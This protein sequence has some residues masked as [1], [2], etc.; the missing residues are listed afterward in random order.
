MG[1]PF[2]GRNSLPRPGREVIK[3]LVEDAW[4]GDEKGGPHRLASPAQQGID[5]VDGDH[6]RPTPQQ[7]FP[8]C[9]DVLK[10]PGQEVVVAGANV[11]RL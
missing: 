11:P 4:L 7:A 9:R 8:Q 1:G 2:F 6:P 5:P 3:G 10:G